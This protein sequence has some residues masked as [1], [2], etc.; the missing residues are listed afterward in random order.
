MNALDQ[1]APSF[2]GYPVAESMGYRQVLETLRPRYREL[3]AEAE[4]FNAGPERTQD[5]QR[6]GVGLAGM[7]YRFG[8]SGSLPV[9]AQA[10]L[11][12]DGRFVIYCSAPDYGQGTNTMLS[13]TAAEALGVDRAQIELV[14]AD[15]ART[16]D[17][18][19]QGASRSTYFVGGAVLRAVE[20]LR[21]AMNTVACEMLDCAPDGLALD[22]ESI[23][24]AEHPGRRISL[25]TLAAEFE[26]SGMPR[27]TAGVFDLS[28]HF[29]PETR[30]EY[31]PLFCTAAHAAQVEVDTRTGTVR[32]LRVAAGPTTWAG[33]ST[34]SMPAARW[35][36]RWLWAWARP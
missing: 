4:E 36:G 31:L 27:K 12:R 26:R 22:G 6:Q 28:P 10:E 5:G 24:C 29:P 19:I 16:P 17:S 13:Q 32:V 30:P 23:F 18:G 20:T 11:A 7:W 1:I 9:E 33:S 14:N 25:A 34:R 21:A 15:T 8:K 3:L 2:L 35:K